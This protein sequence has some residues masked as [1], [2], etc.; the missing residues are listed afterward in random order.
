[1]PD[2]SSASSTQPVLAGWLGRLFSSREDA[3]A[4]RQEIAGF[5]AECRKRGLLEPDE[6]AMLEGVLEVSE[7]HVREIMIPRSRMVVIPQ[8]ETPDEVLKIIV[9]SGHSRFPVIGAD[10]DEIVGILLAKDVLKHYRENAE[11]FS[12]D[13]LLRPA[14][15]VPES[16]R[17][18]TLLKEFRESHQHLA[19]VV[20][21]YG[22]ISGLA[23]IEDVLEQIV[24]SIDDEHD[25][26]EVE[27]IQELEGGRHQVMALTRIDSFNEHFGCELDDEE[28]E[29]I[30]GLIMHELGRLPRRGERLRFGGFEF[31]V[32]RADR[33]RI[34]TVEV[35][36]QDPGTAAADG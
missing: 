22:G 5:L 4:G 19:V 35:V 3:E 25:P 17:L 9:E 6:F 18:S 8:D 12:I 27:P 31:Q 20:D 29:T 26:E 33:R 16:K 36:R 13:A 34:H 21:E 7:T 23:T 32:T 10:R 28:Y 2:D 24:G 14:V 11:D 30:G 15:F 1:M